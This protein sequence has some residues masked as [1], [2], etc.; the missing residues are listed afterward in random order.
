MSQP[1]VSV[2]TP[3]YNRRKFIPTAITCFKAQK[4]P[5]DRMEWIILDDGTDKV[6]DLFA[7]AK[8][9]GLNIR[10]E[11]LPDGIK[12]PI[13]AKR[14]RLNEMAKG[15]I[16]VCWD[17]DDY[18]PPERV[19]K[20]VAKLRSVPNQKVP[21]VG[22]TILHLFFSDRDEIWSIG[23][24][25]QNHCTNG[26]MAYW[27]SYF[28]KNRYDDTAD[29]AEEKKFLCDWQTP[30]LQL[31]SEETML[32]VCHAHN[33]FDKRILLTHNNP[34]LKKS[35]FK[36]QNLVKDKSIRDFYIELAKD[37][38]ELDAPK[39]VGKKDDT[40]PSPKVG[41]KC[42]NKDEIISISV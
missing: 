25:G 22:S 9:D 32:V 7:K 2:L 4:Y 27:R 5:Q 18:Y 20:A 42:S 1:F 15:E 35:K 39:N 14:N 8:A 33:T 34:L 17:D 3:T 13:G 10:Y 41:P 29:K 36:M 21:M 23:P 19:K 26:T 11:A 28:G 16:V 31:Q 12:L 37:Y 24:Y 30:V 38:K 6:G 40:N